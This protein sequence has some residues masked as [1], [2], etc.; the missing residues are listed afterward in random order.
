[1]QRVVSEEIRKCLDGKLDRRGW[2]ELILLFSVEIF[3]ITYSGFNPVPN[4]GL[5][6]VLIALLSVGISDCVIY[7]VSF[8][9]IGRKN[10]SRLYQ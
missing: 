1:T 10:E 4:S 2:T 7:F 3:G 9:K 8:L 5:P 6:K